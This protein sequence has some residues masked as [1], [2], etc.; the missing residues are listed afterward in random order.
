MRAAFSAPA[1][2]RPC[3]FAVPAASSTSAP[4]RVGP[5]QGALTVLALL[6]AMLVPSLTLARPAA[7]EP[8]YPPQFNQISASKYAV[9]SGRQIRFRAQVFQPRSRVTWSTRGHGRTLA[10]GRVVADARGVVV[11][12]I[13]FERV[14]VT[15][16]S[17]SGTGR[18]GTPLTLATRVHVLARQGGGHGAATTGAGGAGG[19]AAAPGP[20]A[21]PAA[22][23]DAGG[24]PVTGTQVALTLG[25][26]LLLV[27]AGLALL[28][29]S[30]RRRV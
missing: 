24:L 20:V 25:L 1:A 3:S 29:A 23:P 7:A 30:R 18:R 19:A 5:V 16:V 4:G 12:R 17:F 22:E 14:G 15:V 10:S 8:D 21:A 13:R 6:A 2:T 27:V 9:Y 26:G 28:L 11:H